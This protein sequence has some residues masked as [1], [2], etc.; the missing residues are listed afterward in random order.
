MYILNKI[1]YRSAQ[2]AKVLL[3]T[4][5]AFFTCA[6]IAI[7]QQIVI[8][9]GAG[10]VTQIAIKEGESALIP[11]K[12]FFFGDVGAPL[13]LIESLVEIH[14]ENRE[15]ECIFS[16]DPITYEFAYPVEHGFVEILLKSS[17]NEMLLW[18]S[19][20]FLELTFNE[21][22]LYPAISPTTIL[23]SDGKLHDTCYF[24]LFHKPPITG[25]KIQ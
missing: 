8:P 14:V 20:S 5:I 25:A 15:S 7:A 2:K 18:E 23:H 11:I 9:K 6:N 22:G 13:H 10:E 17:Y 16:I 1:L 24:T 12:I 21:N 4:S 19:Q 3:F